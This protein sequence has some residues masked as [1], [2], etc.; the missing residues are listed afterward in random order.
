MTYTLAMSP[1]DEA[2]IERYAARENLSV[3]DFIRRTVMDAIKR[4]AHVPRPKARDEMT[5]EEFYAMIDRSMEDARCGRVAPAEEVFAEL[6][7]EFAV[8]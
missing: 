3:P 2:L 7:K 8:E 4:R 1:A 6:E 5:D